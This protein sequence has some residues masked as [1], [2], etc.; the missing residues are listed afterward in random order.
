[1]A[2]TIR[3]IRLM[4]MRSLSNTLRNPVWILVGLFQP[5]L[6]LL[7]FAPLLKGMMGD[8]ALTTFTP[9]LLVMMAIYSSVASGYE[10]IFE[11]KS[12]VVERFRVTPVSRVAMLMGPVLRDVCILIVQCVILMLLAWLMGVQVKPGAAML[13]LLL[14]AVVGIA[15]AA[16]FYGLSLAIKD[17][18]GL[19]SF[20]NTLILP[21]LLLSGILLPLTF[22]PRVIKII[23]LLN[24][25]THIVDATRAIFTN[26]LS[27]PSVAVGFIIALIGSALI[28][29]WATRLFR[30]AV[31]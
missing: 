4:F 9:G 30:T 14:I 23:A 24:P 6:Y 18:N 7:L 21:V 26:D 22:A 16:L 3:D 19:A 29:W 2:K 17:E 20:T 15:M 10:L 11:L 31:G 27:S 8:E 12:G 1:M 25:F 28:S 5:I 13:S